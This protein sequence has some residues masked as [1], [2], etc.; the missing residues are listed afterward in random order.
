MDGWHPSCH[1]LMQNVNNLLEIIILFVIQ[2]NKLKF[3]EREIERLGWLVFV[4]FF[5]SAFDAFNLHFFSAR[6]RARSEYQFIF[7]ANKQN[8]NYGKN[9]N[10]EKGNEIGQWN[11]FLFL[12]LK[13]MP[14]SESWDS[15]KKIRAIIEMR[16]A[17]NSVWLKIW[18]WVEI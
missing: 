8:F 14:S 18:S 3:F 6:S 10:E 11:H 9:N 12:K 2:I 1:A 5:R 4:F 7:A 17:L 16:K 13:I 15:I